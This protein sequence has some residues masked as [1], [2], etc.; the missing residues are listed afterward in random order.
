MR[1]ENVCFYLNSGLGFCT[2]QE[3]GEGQKEGLLLRIT[4][5]QQLCLTEVGFKGLLLMYYSSCC[6]A[7]SLPDLLDSFAQL[8][9]GFWGL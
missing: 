3:P 9:A 2:N 6:P 4:G 8:P 1:I 7:A 5:C